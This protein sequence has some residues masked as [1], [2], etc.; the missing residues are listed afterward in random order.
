MA[1][2]MG[3]LEP[4]GDWNPIAH[5]ATTPADWDQ[6]N[7]GLYGINHKGSYY[8]SNIDSAQK[9]YEYRT[10]VNSQWRN[11][12]PLFV[13]QMNQAIIRHASGNSALEVRVTNAPQRISYSVRSTKKNADGVISAFIFSIAVSFIPAGIITLI[14]REREDLVKH[15]Q[16]VSGVSIYSYWISHYLVDFLKHLIPASIIIG[17][18]VAFNIESFNGTSDLLGATSL[19]FILYGW[20]NIPFSYLVGFLFDNYGTSMTVHFFFN[21]LFGSLGAILVMVLRLID[22]TREAGLQLQWFMRLFPCYAFGYGVVNIGSINTWSVMAGLPPGKTLSVYDMNVAGGDILFLGIFGFIYFFLIFVIEYVKSKGNILAIFSRERDIPYVPKPYDNDVE[23][24]MREVEASQPEDYSVRVKD[25]RKV[26]MLGL[27]PGSKYKVAVDRVSFGIKNGECFTLLGVNGAGKTSTFKILTGE[28]PA[29]SGSAH[30]KG[31][32]TQTQLADARTYVGYCPQFDALLENL[33]V[34]EHLDLYAAI[35]GIPAEKRNELVEKKLV[36]MDLKQYEDKCAGTLSGGNKRKLSV[37]IAMLGNPPIV[38]LD[39]PSTGM[40]PEARRF[41][42]DVITRISTK[43][44][45]SSIILTTHSMEEA[46]ALSTKV[47]IQVDGQIQC[48]G[49]IQ[50]IKS[51]FGQGYEVEVKLII[52]KRDELLWRLQSITQKYEANKLQTFFKTVEEITDFFRTMGIQNQLI[53]AEIKEDGFGS[54]LYQE[55]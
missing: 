29:T 37:A 1:A 5:A 53:Q 39:E 23:R 31:F 40:D 36:E 46:E 42:W 35:K 25:L 47:A 9:I 3:L 24:E 27:L 32:D 41:M 20:A 38:F 14:V 18:V 28:I 17:M 19:L 55:L 12:L 44:K 30:I 50:H 33:T 6:Y 2:V 54:A 49:S 43:R 22:S 10:Q 11:A 51:K 34:R 45:Q 21:F 4:S 7:F 15:Q 48:I 26:Y 52:P 13:N 8:F 16:L